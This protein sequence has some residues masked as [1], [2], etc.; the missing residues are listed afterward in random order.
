MLLSFES[1]HVGWPQPIYCDFCGGEHVTSDCHMYSMKHSWWEQEVH[2]HNQLEE[3]KLSR[4]ENVL[5]QFI[6]VSQ[7][8]LEA[9]QN[10]IQNLA[11]KDGN[12]A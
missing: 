10:L 6:E 5:V 8:T 9:N 12:L 2:P 11:T 4:L 1:M 7:A 3:E